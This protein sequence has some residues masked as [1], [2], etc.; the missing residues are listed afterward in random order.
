M[1]ETR[2]GFLKIAGAAV[3]GGAA[4]PAVAALAR[5]GHEDKAKG[6]ERKL[7]MVIDLRACLRKQ[8][9]RDCITACHRAHNVPD[10]AR[11]ELGLDELTVRKREIK[12]IWKE[13][14][15][16][17][18]P[19]DENPY[20]EEGL[21]EKDVLVFC[22]HCE[23][24]PCVRV[25]PTKATWKRKSD[26]VVMMD[27]HRCIGCRYCVVACPYGS[28]SFNWRDPKPVLEMSHAMNLSYPHRSKGV[29]EK[30][31]FC[32][33]RVG[34]GLQPACVEACPARAMTF[35]DVEDP[36]SPVRQLLRSRYAIR[37]KP[38]LGTG[39]QIYYLVS[40]RRA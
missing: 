8:G 36:G 30:C 1:D 7:A 13:R 2:R 15:E 34:E 4:V 5:A 10:L 22:N 17:A 28:R 32:E 6:P 23:N 20:L 35:G 29:V 14:F 37:R 31:T 40:E 33:E 9:C 16:R 24:P 18:F 38:G 26:G 11:P 39:P 12:W 21:R 27:M 19:D 25:C 3:L